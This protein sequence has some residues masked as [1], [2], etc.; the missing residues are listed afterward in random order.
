MNVKTIKRPTFIEALVPITFLIIIISVSI[1]KFGADPQIPL[2]LATIVAVLLGFKLGYKWDDMEKGMISTINSSMQAILIQMIIGIIIGTWILAG[3]V[4]TM[5]YYGL[6]ILSPAIFL[7]SAAIL[8]AIISVATGSAWTTAGTVGIA[9][10]GVGQGLGMP[11]PLVAGTIISGAYFGDK[12]S[13]LSDSTNLAAAVTEVKLFDHIGHMLK[14][15]SVSFIIA[16]I[17][18]GF[19]GMKYSSSALDTA[20][21]N[22]L[23]DAL[24]QHFH[25]SPILLLP[26]ILVVSIVIMKVPAVPGLLCGGILGGIFAIIFQKSTLADVILV[27]HYGFNSQSGFEAM[28]SLLSRGGLDSMMYTVSLIIVAMCFG[29][30]IEK[31]KVLEVIAEKLLIFTK[32]RGSLVLTTALSSIFCNFTMADQYLAI[33]VP[34]RMFRKSY[35]EKNLKLK[36]LSRVLEDSG[37]LTSSLVPWSTCGAFMLTTLGVHPFAYLP[38]AFLNLINPIVSIIYGYTGFTMEKDEILSPSEEIDDSSSSQEL[39]NEIE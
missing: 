4:P 37:T 34:G 26:P 1:L 31:I 23:L 16:L 3:I 33:V 12:M 28:D 10:L 14:T 20:Q 13:P 30:V 2:L 22:Q 17:L 39:I 25:I 7:P 35:E 24:K 15:T 36:N 6:Q 32:T 9:L 38:F 29:G 8:C 19:V 18:Y 21:I 27:S 11:L 5:I